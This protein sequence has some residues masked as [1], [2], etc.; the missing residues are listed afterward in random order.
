MDTFLG[1]DGKEALYD[2]SDTHEYGWLC[3][4]GMPIKDKAGR[5]IGFFLVDISLTEVLRGMGNFALKYYLAMICVVALFSLL[6]LRRSRITLV[7]PINQISKAAYLYTK[8]QSTE[9]MTEK[10][11]EK[12]DIRTG[13]VRNGVDGYTRTVDRQIESRE[14]RPR[15]SCNKARERNVRAF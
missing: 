7:E 10:Y 4:A 8:A 2:I 9:G 12:L 6:L 1:W 3:T 13:D 5:E 15:I 14:C 11:F